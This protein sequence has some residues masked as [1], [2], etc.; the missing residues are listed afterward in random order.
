LV[1]SGRVFWAEVEAVGGVKSDLT[2]E[3]NAIRM[4]QELQR[5]YLKWSSIFYVDHHSFNV[6]DKQKPTFNVDDS[7]SRIINV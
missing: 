6:N 3:L 7:M 4:L 2:D 5:W 1:D